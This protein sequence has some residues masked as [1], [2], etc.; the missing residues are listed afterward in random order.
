MK[1]K[2]I[3]N[4]VLLLIGSFFIF[5]SNGKYHFAL[6][7]WIFPIFILQI[8]RKEIKI[9]S[10]LVIALLF[11]FA[12][13]FSFWYTFNNPTSILF[14]I[15]ALIGF[16]MGLLFYVDRL[17]YDRIDGFKATLI[18]PILYTSFDFLSNLLNPLGTMGVLGYS[19]HEFLSFSQLASITGMWG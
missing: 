18:L 3:K 19:Q 4:T 6:A 9:Y 16:F 2:L 11:G 5:F 10:V 1:N 12:F 15:P 7:A 17:L 14:Y 8:S 13:L